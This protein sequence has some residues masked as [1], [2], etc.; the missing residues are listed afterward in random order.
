MNDIGDKGALAIAEALKVN[1]SITGIYLSGNNNIGTDALKQIDTQIEENKQISQLIKDSNPLN[2]L[3]GKSERFVGTVL[4]YIT[5]NKLPS[6]EQ[7]YLFCLYTTKYRIDHF[8]THKD[9]LDSYLKELNTEET[10][11]IIDAALE[12]SSKIE[13]ASWLSSKKLAVFWLINKMDL[14]GLDEPCLK[15]VISSIPTGA[16]KEVKDLF[17]KATQLLDKKIADSTQHIDNAEQSNLNQQ[18]N[19]DSELELVGNLPEQ[20][21]GV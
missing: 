7:S 10:K 5:E 16:F 13:A 8:I 17:D 20:E 3:D 19:D 4:D 1:K 14:T 15:K 11:E 9:K 12:V 2:H 21:E 6:E 18:E